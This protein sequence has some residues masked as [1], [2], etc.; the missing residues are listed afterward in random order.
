MAVEGCRDE[1]MKRKAPAMATGC[2]TLSSDGG[3]VRWRSSIRCTGLQMM[4]ALHETSSWQRKDARGRYAVGG[5]TNEIQRDIFLDTEQPFQ[6][7]NIHDP[8]EKDD[9]SSEPRFN[10][11]SASITDSGIYL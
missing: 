5:G 8:G 2:T 3:R 1:R 7:K 4:G 11:L 6:K 9:V 10:R